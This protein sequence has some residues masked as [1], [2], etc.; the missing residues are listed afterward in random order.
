M[1]VAAL[2]HYPVKSLCG[3]AVDVLRLD[4]LGPLDDRRWMLVDAAGTFVTQRMHGQLVRIRARSDGVQL[5]LNLPDGQ[6]L[7]F[8][9]SDVQ[10][11]VRVWRDEVPALLATGPSETLSAYLG[12]PVRLVRLP[13]APVRRIDPAR[14]P[15]ER[16]VGF[17]DG[18]PIL[19]THQASLA[20]VESWV[21]RPLD[22]RRFRPNI[23]IAGADPF[24]EDHWQ[25][26]QIGEVV[27]DLVK[28][29]SRCVM[30][31]VD[32]DTG[33]REA[34]GQPLKAL[35][36]HRKTAEG[37]IF[38]QNALHRTPGVLRVGDPVRVLAR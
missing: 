36:L 28:P 30:T 35:S 22:M 9:A 32:P 4:A 38:G 12:V 27:L 26:L 3:Q 24:A 16:F 10:V 6:I 20:A 31:T 15:E 2:Y 34:D 8:E 19:V 11:S 23:V 21:G 14:V 17:A 5:Q 29:C 7:G 25:S 1:H 37:V 18:F 33:V 13:D